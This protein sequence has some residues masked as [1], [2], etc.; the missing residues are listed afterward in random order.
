MKISKLRHPV[1]IQS[2]DDSATPDAFGNIDFT[3]DDNWT[4][5]GSRRCQI[6]PVTG[7]ELY[8]GAQVQSNLTHTLRFRADEL[9]GQISSRWRIVFGS[10]VFNVERAFT[11]ME[12]DWEV[13]VQCVERV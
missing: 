8:H 11:V 3:N 12:L 4:T 2:P 9:T 6:R 5:E 13:E 1:V 7:K 10:R